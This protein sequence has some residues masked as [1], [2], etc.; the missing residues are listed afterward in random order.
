MSLFASLLMLV[1]AAIVLVRSVCVAAHLNRLEWAGHPLA[2]IGSA[3]GYS[4]LGSGAA[5]MALG[6]AP[7]PLLLLVGVA[8]LVICDRRDRC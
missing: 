5:G 2:F 7:A 4:L 3:T 1:S 8:L 6:Y